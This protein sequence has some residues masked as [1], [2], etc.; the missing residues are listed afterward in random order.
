M[1]TTT[2]TKPLRVLRL[3][4]VEAKTG[5]SV[6]DI[7]KKMS[8]GEFPQSIVL[9]PNMRGWVEIELDMWIE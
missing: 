7:Y 1:A 5:L 9:G 8:K 6:P 4:D 2:P 3:P